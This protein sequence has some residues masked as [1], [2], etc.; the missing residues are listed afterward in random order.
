MR[1]R[2]LAD[3]SRGVDCLGPPMPTSP[4]ALGATDELA[5]GLGSS[6]QPS[7]LRVLLASSRSSWSSSL[8][9]RLPSPLMTSLSFHESPS[10]FLGHLEFR[11]Q[12]VP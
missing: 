12:E 8:A 4:S 9:L 3:V 1:E 11:L 10:P 2:H 7:V 6:S 5:S